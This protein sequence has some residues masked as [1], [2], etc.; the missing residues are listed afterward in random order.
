MSDS[1][2]ITQSIKSK[3]VKIIAEYSKLNQTQES[4]LKTKA[5]LEELL[6][7][8]KKIIE[9]LEERN[10]IIKLANEINS[11]E[12]GNRELKLKINEHIRH[13]D[14]CIRLLSE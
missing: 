4:L 8:Q 2:Q 14:E 6:E 11:S 1:N 13:L 10:K 3:V 5:K 9:N 7:S 12:E